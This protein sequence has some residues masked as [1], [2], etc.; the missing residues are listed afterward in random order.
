MMTKVLDDYCL[1]QNITDDSER[2]YAAHLVLWLFINGAKS[3]D[4][5]RAGLDR[6][7]RIQQDHF[8]GG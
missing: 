4:E 6:E 2:D 3:A 5:I 1:A 7:G 8:A